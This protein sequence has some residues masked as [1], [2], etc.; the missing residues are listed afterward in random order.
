MPLDSDVIAI[1]VSDE[2]YSFKAIQHSGEFAVNIPN[3]KLVKQVVQC[4]SVSGE[5]TDKFACFA[6]TPVRARKIRAPLVKECIG[7]LECKLIGGERRLAKKYNMFIARVIYARAERG[8]FRTRWDM[9]REEAHTLHHL[10]GN[11]FAVPSKKK[12][13]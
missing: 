3:K 4:G 10:G 7:H 12:V 5:D 9:A 6:L 8:C 11:V 1:V 2:N 13:R